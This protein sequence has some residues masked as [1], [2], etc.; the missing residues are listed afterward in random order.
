MRFISRFYYD[1]DA[2]EGAGGAAAAPPVTDPPPVVIPEDV[3]KELAELR[4]FKETIAKTEPAKTPEQLKKAAEVDKADFIKY[5]AEN[6]LMKVDDITKFESLKAKAD[7]D[8]VFESFA[9]DIKDELTEELKAE[10]P[11]I[12]EA[13]IEEKVKEKFESEYPINS[14]NPK[15]KERAEKKLARDAKEIR[16]PLETP[17]TKAQERYTEFKK[18]N[19]EVPVFN[20]LMDEIIKESTPEKIVVKTK[21][22]DQEID[23]EIGLTNEQRTEVEK[24]FKGHKTFGRYYNSSDEEK[25]K[26]KAT[27]Q[28]KIETYIKANIF[29]QAVAKGFEKGKGIGTA[30]G[31][32]TGANNPFPLQQN[33]K[34]ETKVISLEESNAKA[35]AQR[36][37]YGR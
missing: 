22:G 11:E 18:V 36:E 9:T 12:T 13:E 34:Q 1:K 27:I 28:K 32:T 7:R 37:K 29:E 20:K 26:F 30:Q 4:A 8:L 25:G 2:N 33:K 6:D 5:S 15:A 3:Q 23:V 10:N 35:A 14:K 24:I 16:N 17:Y 31:S 19:T 21:D